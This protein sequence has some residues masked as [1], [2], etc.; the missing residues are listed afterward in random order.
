MCPYKP[1]FSYMLLSVD[2]MRPASHC[3]ALPY[4]SLP[5]IIQALNTLLGAFIKCPWAAHGGYPFL[6]TSLAPQAVFC[7][8]PLEPEQE[9]ATRSVAVI[10]QYSTRAFKGGGWAFCF[11]YKG[12]QAANAYGFVRFAGE[13]DEYSG[14]I[15]DASGCTG[16]NLA[17]D[18]LDSCP[19]VARMVSKGHSIPSE[20]MVEELENV[21]KTL[22]T[23]DHGS[24]RPFDEEK[25]IGSMRRVSKDYLR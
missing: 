2:F 4:F 21:L 11:D 5:G 7:A 16:T 23:E 9:W 6:T 19:F 13:G 22:G 3:C 20:A 25:L 15:R 18:I 1:A 10:P 12:Q 8:A 17:M 24:V 14:R